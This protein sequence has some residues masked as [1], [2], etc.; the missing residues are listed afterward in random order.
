MTNLVEEFFRMARFGA[1]GLIS[2]LVHFLVAITVGHFVDTSSV[3]LMNTCG[4]LVAL[5]VSFFG[6]YH[7]TFSSSQIYKHAFAKFF[8]VALGAFAASSL[9]IVLASYAQLPD[10][11]RLFVGAMIIPIISYIANKKLVF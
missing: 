10:I 2:T 3:I 7:V 11:W 1:V 6:H 4:F 9:T 5:V 8:L